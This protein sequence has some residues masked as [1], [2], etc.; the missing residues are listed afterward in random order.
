[1][2]SQDAKDNGREL[3]SLL[4]ICRVPLSSDGCDLCHIEPRMKQFFRML[5]VSFL[6]GVGFFLVAANF[7]DFQRAMQA[8]AVGVVVSV[9]VLLFIVLNKHLNDVFFERDTDE[10]LGEPTSMGLSYSI[11]G[12]ILYLLPAAM[13][14][15]GLITLMINFLGDQ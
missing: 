8:G 2:W 15:C 11:V 14:G 12:C 5:W 6:W 13:M 3:P 4:R 1:M 10:D 7:V 9:V